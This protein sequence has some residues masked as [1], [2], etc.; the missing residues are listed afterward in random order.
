M[1]DN[2][3]LE[4]ESL[5]AKLE[6]A[7]EAFVGPTRWGNRWRWDETRMHLTIYD[8]DGDPVATLHIEQKQ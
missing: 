1:S 6:D 3:T 2:N 5:R 8:V 4:I 7:A